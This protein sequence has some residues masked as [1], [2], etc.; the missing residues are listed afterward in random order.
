[1][2]DTSVLRNDETI[3]H[4]Q[5]L[6]ERTTHGAFPVVT[7]NNKLV[8]MITVKDVIGREETELIDKVMT[9]IRLLDR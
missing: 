2:T 7:A 5:K 3:H 1:M 4:F 6:N 9:K 8:G